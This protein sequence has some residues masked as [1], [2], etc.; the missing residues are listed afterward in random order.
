[1]RG[2][3]ESHFF[4]RADELYRKRRGHCLGKHKNCLRKKER[5]D[6]NFLNKGKDELS[7]YPAAY[8]LDRVDT[9]F[10]GIG[11]HDFKDEEKRPRMT[12]KIEA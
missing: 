10:S 1:M 8:L 3:R 9:F 11:G 6:G 5:Q 4:W 7:I 2:W 12:P